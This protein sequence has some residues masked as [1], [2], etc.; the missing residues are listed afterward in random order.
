M[1]SCSK[2]SAS[3]AAM[4]AKTDLLTKQEEIQN[5]KDRKKQQ[6]KFYKGALQAQRSER[7]SILQGD[8]GEL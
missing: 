2:S 8:S 7:G 4:S 3:T 1:V 5:E 6:S